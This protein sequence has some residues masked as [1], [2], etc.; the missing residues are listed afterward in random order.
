MLKTKWKQGE[1]FSDL[2]LPYPAG[3]TTIALFQIMAYNQYPNPHIVNGI[4][5]PYAYLRNKVSVS[6]ID[7]P[8]ANIVAEFVK[9]FIESV[10]HTQG[11]SQGSPYTLIYPNQAV[12]YFESVG[13]SNVKIHRNP[14][15]F[16]YDKIYESLNSGYPV[17]VSA[18]ANGTNGH[19]WVIDGY[20]DQFRTG[21]RYG[22]E[23]GKYYG[24]AGSQ[25]RILVHCNWGWGG[26][27]D[28][29]YYAGVFATNEGP[30]IYDEISLQG[31]S[32]GDYDSFYRIVTYEIPNEL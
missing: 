11:Y 7:N 17:L 18:K 10:S 26:L 3:C 20:L 12:K 2:V 19:T 25:S 1:P 4:E 5:M 24:P 22:A 9:H 15:K 8:Y 6:P 23:T 14:T 31:E 29:Y 32:D 16:D 28:G 21:S 13:Y 27:S 30:V